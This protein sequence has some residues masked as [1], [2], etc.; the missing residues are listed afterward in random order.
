LAVR[1]IWDY[2]NICSY[3]A[4]AKPREQELAR[5]MRRRGMAMKVI[6]SEL[7]VSPGSVHRW[8][9]DIEL[10]PEQH[11]RN[12]A[13]AGQRRGKTWREL[14]RKRRR[15][16]QADGRAR[17][18]ADDLLH[19]AGCMLYWAEGSKDRNTLVFANSDPEMVRFFC[20]FLRESFDI[21]A[22]ELTIRINAYTGNGQTMSEIE[23]WW[24]NTLDL[25]QESLR[26]GIENHR[27]TSSSGLRKNK[28]PR[29][30][31]ALRVKRST[32]LV[33][34]I[35]GAIQEY[36]GFDEPRW[37]DCDPASPETATTA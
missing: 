23:G 35:Y 21:P 36:A 34:H 13:L 2:T 20:R 33:Q 14:N 30:V 19:Q 32:W 11:A 31:C 16:Y 25:P 37:L 1:L 5:E 28:L 12:V 15:A 7:S 27:P 9:S 29:G 4:M 22:D 17:A 24:L 3:P 10:T 8:T 26:K 18:R 6:A